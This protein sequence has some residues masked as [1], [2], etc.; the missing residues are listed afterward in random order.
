MKYNRSRMTNF[1]QL[2]IFHAVAI[3]GSFPKAA[4]A[5]SI[6]QPAV[7]IQVS[8]LEDADWQVPEVPEDWRELEGY[9]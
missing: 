8:G 3:H 1:H 7:S 6:S 4:V 5:L 2:Q 9:S